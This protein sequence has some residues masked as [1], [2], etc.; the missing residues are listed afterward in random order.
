MN[1]FQEKEN[2][3]I[4]AEEEVGKRRTDKNKAIYMHSLNGRGHGERNCVWRGVD[5]MLFC[6]LCFNISSC[7]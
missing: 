3:D 1:F 7:G 6:V 5:P 2:C 4:H